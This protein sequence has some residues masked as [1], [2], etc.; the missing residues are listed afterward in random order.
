MNDHQ[1]ESRYEVP[2]PALTGSVWAIFKRE[3]GQYF[4]SPIAYFVAFV[5]LLIMGLAFN[6]YLEIWK[7]Q[8]TTA[9]AP[10]LVGFF[11]SL[12]VFMAPLLTMRLLAEENREGTIELLLTMPVRDIDI[13]LGKFLGAWAYYTLLLLVTVVYQLILASVA[14]PDMG[15]AIASYIG[16]WLYG[17]ASLAVGLMFSALTEN[18][19]VAGFLGLSALMVMFQANTFALSISDPNLRELVRALSTGTH[20]YRSFANGIVRLEDVLFFVFVMAGALFVAVR[21]VESRRWR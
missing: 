1:A 21:M 6:A 15:A 10:A 11:V 12:M 8:R 20:Y 7:D 16:A 2:P 18:Q 19:I 9:S 5:I 17:G 13:V 3:L 4:V 14:Q